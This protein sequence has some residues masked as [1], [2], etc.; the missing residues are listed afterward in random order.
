MSPITLTTQRFNLKL[1]LAL[2]FCFLQVSLYAQ[3]GALDVSWGGTGI[4]TTDVGAG[5]DRGFAVIQ[6]TDGKVVVGGFS[7]NGTNND[8]GLTR[9]NTDG[10]L[11]GSW[12]IGGIVTTPIGPANDAGQAIIQQPDGK[13]LMAGFASNGIDN[14]FAV[15]RFNT[16]GTLDTTFNGTGIAIT[17]IGVSRIDQAHDITL[18]PDGKILLAG[19]SSNGSDNDFAIARY[20]TAGILDITFDG[21]GIVTTDFSST[22]DV[23]RSIEVQSDGKILVGGWSSNGLDFDFAVA[24]Y[25][26]IGTLDPTFDV[27]GKVITDFTGFD[28]QGYSMVLQPDG[29]ILVSGVTSNGTTLDFAIARYNTN[30]S[31]DNTFDTDGRVNTDFFGDN[32]FG[33][34]IALQNDDKILVGGQCKNGTNQDFGLARYNPNGSLDNTYDTDGIVT[35]DLGGGNDVGWAVTVQIDGR[36]VVAGSNNLSSTSSFGV[37]RYLICE[38]VDT[39]LTFVPADSSITANGSGIAF[40]WSNCDSS[41]SIIPGATDQ[42]YIIDANGSYAVII[43]TNNYC[44]DTSS[45]FTI[46]NLS[47]QEHSFDNAVFVFPNPTTGPLLLAFEK[48]LNAASMLLYNLSGQ[49]LLSSTGLYGNKVGFDMS[50]QAPGIY[51]LE[52]R[53]GVKVSRLK[54]VKQ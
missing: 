21:D 28:D 54:V 1:S 48:P 45:C 44:G 11:D 6:Q 4:V 8:F 34:S 53:E 30:G 40:Q 9:Y 33:Y 50:S 12:G 43:T 37:T 15:A 39:S 7:N 51:I 17:P 16:N 3:P 42:S 22:E 47:T 18:Q 26:T 27:D 31:L 49:Q 32:D 20:T 14:D 38:I 41:Y 5:N 52:I 35:T 23:G 29:K 36:G 10:S 46:I 13:I 24:R 19:Y 2:I 25:D